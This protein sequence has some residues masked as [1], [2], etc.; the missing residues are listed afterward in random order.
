MSRVPVLVLAGYLGAGKTTLLN[1]LLRHAGGTRIGAVVNDFGSVNVDAMLV[2]GQVDATVSFGNGCLCCA[3]DSSELDAMLDRLVRPD[4]PVDVVVIE[5]SGI[6]EPADLVRRLLSSANPHLEFGGLV[7]VVDAVEF[8]RA[9]TRHP[10]LDRHL[11]LADL[12]VVNKTDRLDDAEV[13]AVLDTVR[14][15]ADGATV[16]AA[17][18]G[19]IAPGLLFDRTDRDSGA[20]RQLSFADLLDD[21]GIDDTHFH[22]DYRTVMFTADQP[23]NPR[24]LVEYLHQRPAGLFRVKGPVD[25]GA[26]GFGDRYLLNAVGNYVRFRRSPW[27]DGESPRTRIVVIGHDADPDEAVERLAECVRPTEDDDIFAAL[28]HTDQDD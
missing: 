28:R 26:V 18:H 2:A 13:T 7:E 6:A 25:F 4:G 9:R 19:R 11:R 14:K 17:D 5:A 21:D 1:H 8:E 23:L 10:D 27:P 12:V 3:V 22:E 15:L 24:A 20:G 16:V